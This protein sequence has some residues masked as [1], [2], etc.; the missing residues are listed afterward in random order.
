MERKESHQEFYDRYD[1]NIILSIKLFQFF[2]EY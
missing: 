1:V 2:L